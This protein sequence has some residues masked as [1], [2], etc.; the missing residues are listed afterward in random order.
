VLNEIVIDPKFIPIG[1]KPKNNPTKPAKP[2]L[3]ATDN[4]SS[5]IRS[6]L[7]LLKNKTLTKQYPGKNEIKIKL[8]M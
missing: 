8:R 3:K 1:D 4:T 2:K 5:S 7:F 6:I